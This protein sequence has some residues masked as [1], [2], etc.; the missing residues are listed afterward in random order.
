MAPITAQVISHW[1][2]SDQPPAEAEAWSTGRFA[3]RR[4]AGG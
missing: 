4:P 3:D 2:A 1:I